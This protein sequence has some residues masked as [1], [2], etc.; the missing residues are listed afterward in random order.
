MVY[1]DVRPDDN[2]NKGRYEGCCNTRHCLQ[3]HNERT[4]VRYYN[5]GTGSYYCYFCAIKLNEANGNREEN[6]K[7]VGTH[8]MVQH[9]SPEQVI[10]F[11]DPHGQSLADLEC[12]G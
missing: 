10:A 1:R 3:E 12:K 9:L 5:F 2:P 7:Y 8:P 11:G 6:M 4:P